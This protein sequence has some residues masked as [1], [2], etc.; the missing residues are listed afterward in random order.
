MSEQFNKCDC[1]HYTKD[2]IR[3]YPIVDVARG[4]DGSAMLCYDC[5]K[6]QRESI[7]AEGHPVYDWDTLSIYSAAILTNLVDV[8]AITDR[9]IAVLVAIEKR[10]RNH[11]FCGEIL[12]DA[13]CER[14][15]SRLSEYLE[16]D[17]HDLLERMGEEAV[18][19]AHN[20]IAR[21]F[22]RHL[23]GCYDLT[24]VNADQL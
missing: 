14:V 17:E 3:K 20:L 23:A 4:S 5:Y 10:M 6:M 8:Q 16:D 2:E 19:Q 9:A 21:E 15:C 7:V 18:Q 24:V 11:D 1:G 13:W 22:V 12:D